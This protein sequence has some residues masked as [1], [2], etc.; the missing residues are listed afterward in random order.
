MS[1]NEQIENKT[2][3]YLALRYLG[4]AEIVAY[5]G[6][7]VWLC[8]SMG[9]SD[10]FSMFGQFFVFF[11]LAGLAT[12]VPSVLAFLKAPSARDPQKIQTAK[13]L[14]KTLFIQVCV[15]L[16]PSM[17]LLGSMPSLAIA[18]FAGFIFFGVMLSITKPILASIQSVPVPT[19]SEVYVDSAQEVHQGLY[20]AKCG[21]PLGTQGICPKCG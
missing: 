12:L 7:F 9:N 20:C 19:G 13:T 14:Q 6:L 17:A 11:Y 10:V 15:A 5:L 18:C 1:T 2:D 21:S 4:F 8:L 3:P 16:V